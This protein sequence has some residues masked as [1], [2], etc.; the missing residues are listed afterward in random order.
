MAVLSSTIAYGHPITWEYRFVDADYVLKPGDE[1]VSDMVANLIMHAFPPGDIDS[2]TGVKTRCI[3]K[4][5]NPA[6]IGLL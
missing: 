5:T 4:R 3:R 2:A 6:G 1:L